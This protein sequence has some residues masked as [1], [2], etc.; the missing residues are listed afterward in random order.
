M[1]KS[2]SFVQNL[3]S[4]ARSGAMVE[5]FEKDA[6]GQVGAGLLPPVRSESLQMTGRLLL[7]RE[8]FAR[9]GLHVGCVHV[10]SRDPCRVHH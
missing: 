1:R 4:E 9:L 8:V 2:L 3:S 10:L 7:R 6:H 5:H